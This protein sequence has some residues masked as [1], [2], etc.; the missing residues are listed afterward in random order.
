MKKLKG[1]TLAEQAYEELRSQ[2][3]SGRLPAGQRLAPDQL[4]DALGIS[5]TPVKEAIALLER[6]G[7]VV[8]EARRGTTVRQFAP[9]DIEEVFEARTLLELHAVRR[10]MAAGRITPAFVARLRAVLEAHIAEV[11]KQTEDGLAA[12][13]ALDREFHELIVE[14]G[15]NE[16]IA[17]W[18]S[19]IQRQTQT[20]KNFTLKT[21]T[22]ERT[23]QEHTAIVEALAGGD[24]EAA[25]DALRFHLEKSRDAMLSRAAEEVPARA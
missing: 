5:Q 12:A 6:D 14:R 20:I 22:L 8:G 10:A 3:V 25:A 9:A 15:G 16:T 1:A 19:V 2:I 11:M 23:M 24:A 7:L 21:Y 18:H 4:A 17:G 13:I